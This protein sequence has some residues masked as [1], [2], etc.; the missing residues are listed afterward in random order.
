M[1]LLTSISLSSILFLSVASAETT[2]CF[3]ENH[4]DMSTIEEINL[5]GGV[6]KGDKSVKD[7]KRDGW[8]VDDIKITQTEKG[9]NY[10]YVFKKDEPKV[11]TIDEAALETKILQRLE[12]RKKEEIEIKKR[13][14]YARKSKSGEN[15]Y[16]NKCISC[17][18]EKGELKARGVSRP[19]KDLN[20]QDFQI[21]IRDYNLGSYDRG[22][23]FVMKPYALLMDDNDVKNVYIYIKSINEK[24]EEAKK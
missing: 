16:K 2:M 12:Q 7:M 9:T 21:S 20:L 5:N 23:A 11:A 10:I 13:E 14:I 19:I 8:N 3:K 6:C 17:H 18:G 1:R 22:M 15:L 24:K 4:K